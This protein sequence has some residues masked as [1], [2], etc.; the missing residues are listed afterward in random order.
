MTKKEFIKRGRKERVKEEREREREREREHEKLGKKEIIKRERERKNQQRMAN[1]MR[2]FVGYFFAELSS[3]T[4]PV[5]SFY[6]SFERFNSIEKKEL[7]H[8][9][10]QISPTKAENK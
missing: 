2:T 10:R 7:K 3:L 4:K 5:L 6:L 8:S 1:P 9:S